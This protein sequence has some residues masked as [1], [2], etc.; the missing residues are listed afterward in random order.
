MIESG[1]L[2]TFRPPK[3]DFGVRADDESKERSAT[4]LELFYDIFYVAVLRILSYGDFYT[5][6][7]VAEFIALFITIWWSWLMVT[8]YDTKY[9]T[10]DIVHRAGKLIQMFGI[11]KGSFQS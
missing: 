10:D 9:D 5:P 6:A 2:N 4:W 7:K 8:M 1:A 3:Q 11:G